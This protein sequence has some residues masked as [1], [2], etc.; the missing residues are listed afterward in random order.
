MRPKS[1]EI[2][3]GCK[4]K[5]VREEYQHQARQRRDDAISLN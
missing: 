5:R 1:I 3:V 4:S 2:E